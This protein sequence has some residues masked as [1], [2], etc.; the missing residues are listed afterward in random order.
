MEKP[1]SGSIDVGE[2]VALG[3]VD[4]SRDHLNDEKSVWDEIADGQEEIELGNKTVKSRAYV[5]AFNFKGADQ[6]KKVSNLSGGERNRVHLAKMLKKSTNVLLFDEPTNDLD[7][8]TLRNLEEA[9]LDYSG[10]AFVISHDRW[11][12][13]RIA[14]HIL[15][16]EDDDVVWY[17]GNF[18]DYEKNMKSR[19]GISSNE[20]IKYKHKK[21]AI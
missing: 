8:D 12:L 5:S 1:D 2:T 20:D 17:E 6:Q 15:A 13:D 21:L 7:I 14:T 19:K 3:Y 16:F 11:F 9:I 4:Q 10:C 18:E